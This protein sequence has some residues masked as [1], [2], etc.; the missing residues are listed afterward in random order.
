MSRFAIA[1]LAYVVLA[2]LA[3]TTLSATVSFA[4][5]QVPLSVITLVVLGM[6]AFRTWLHHK[7]ELLQRAEPVN[8]HGSAQGR[9]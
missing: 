7:R 6:F 4:G 1:M 5:R 9:H 8:G 2:I 3:V